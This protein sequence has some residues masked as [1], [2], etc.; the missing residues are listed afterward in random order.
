M[1]RPTG[2]SPT[3]DVPT[4]ALRVLP[5]G[6][7][8][9]RSYSVPETPAAAWSAA[10]SGRRLR[11]ARAALTAI[12]A[13]QTL[14]TL[15]RP[16]AVS[17]AEALS[18]T[19]GDAVLSGAATGPWGVPGLAGASRAYPLLAALTDPLGGVDA[20]RTLSLGLMLLATVLLYGLTT[21]LFN[22]RAGL[23]AAALFAVL[24]STAV[25]GGSA[26]PEAAGLCLLAATARLLVGADRAVRW[27][28]ASAVVM[29]GAAVLTQYW[30]VLCLPGILLLA[31]ARDAGAGRVRGRRTAVIAVVAPCVAVAA[32]A[33]LSTAGPPGG[34]LFPSAAGDA[35]PGG[36]VGTATGLSLAVAA[37][38]AGCLLVRA[39][40]GEHP[41]AVVGRQAE[42][43]RRLLWI[44]ALLLAAV[45]PLAAAR[46]GGAAGYGLGPS[47]AL[48]WFAAP[49]AGV[50]ATRLMG[51]H[52]RF[53]QAGIALWTA[54]LCLGV[55]Q[56]DRW[57]AGDPD[58]ARLA[59]VMA[60][61]AAGTGTYLGVP[62]EV[63]AYQLRRTVR[64]GQWSDCGGPAAGPRARASGDPLAACARAVRAGRFQMIVLD[65]A[66]RP[67]V[68]EAVRNALRGNRHYRLRAELVP[69]GTTP[70]AG[71]RVWARVG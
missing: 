20:A 58:P 31:A 9:D 14:L 15:R 29:T 25:L 4:L 64:P 33:G 24:P 21:R 62:A 66:T 41:S 34:P 61:Y 57:F 36:G 11:V 68:Q 26:T 69:Y 63:A 18:L 10:G 65:G 1:N 51:R 5:D 2:S 45:A 47:A 67:A 28:A 59:R 23:C 3:P 22:V 56:A 30:T 44:V 35:A 17:P 54:L 71:Y 48:V 49:L 12:L 13:V 7:R 52:F 27:A 70:G 50:G 37:V 19:A 6:A 46:V 39:R 42:R 32:A 53:P 60:P 43:G 55:P 16:P 8:E 38:G 40:M